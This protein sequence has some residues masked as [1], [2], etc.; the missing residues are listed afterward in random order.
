MKHNMWR[1]I[2]IGCDVLRLLGR[3]AWGAL[4]V[5]VIVWTG[6]CF[7]LAAIGGFVAIASAESGGGGGSSP[8]GV[9]LHPEDDPTKGGW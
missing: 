6:A 8:D 3:L 9:N 1:A 7:V 2:D 4:N 5:L